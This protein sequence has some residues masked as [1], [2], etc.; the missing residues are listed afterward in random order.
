MIVTLY[1]MR[2]ARLAYVVFLALSLM[3]VSELS[4]RPGARGDPAADLVA[5]RGGQHRCRHGRRRRAPL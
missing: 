2:I 1:R 5:Q 4:R 3:G